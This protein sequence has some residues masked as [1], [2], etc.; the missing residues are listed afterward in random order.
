MTDENVTERKSPLHTAC[1]RKER[2]S[3]SMRAQQ[4]HISVKCLENTIH[5]QNELV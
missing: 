4:Y 3:Y 2:R 1:H 5:H